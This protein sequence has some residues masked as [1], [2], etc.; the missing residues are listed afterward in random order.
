MT[1]GYKVKLKTA[2]GQYLRANGCSLPPWKDSISH[3]NPNWRSTTKDWILWNV[4]VVEIRLDAQ[5]QQ[6]RQRKQ[7]K[8]NINS[9]HDASSTGGDDD[10]D[11]TEPGSP[12]EI[13]LTS[14]K[15]NSP[16]YKKKN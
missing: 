16:S 3:D 2:N 14:P 15:Q 5:Q 10:H 7:E 1:E 8:T 11:Q 12:T 6:E 9:D 4:D 13:D